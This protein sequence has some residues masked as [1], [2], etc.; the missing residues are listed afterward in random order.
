MLHRKIRSTIYQ[1]HILLE[2][3]ILKGTAAEKT[4]CYSKTS[5]HIWCSQLKVRVA[6]Y[7]R[8][9]RSID[10]R[11]HSPNIGRR[12]SASR[13]CILHNIFLRG[14]LVLAYF[15]TTTL[16]THGRSNMNSTA[17]LMGLGALKL[18][19]YTL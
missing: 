13:R 12:T 5:T 1:C 6:Q 19:T 16:P 10:E 15:T 2:N 18:S 9:T 4:H 3:R 11:T 17:R 8:R 7:E 14:V